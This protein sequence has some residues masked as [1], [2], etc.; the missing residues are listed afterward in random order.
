MA[1]VFL[2]LLA[3][4]PS[5]A[6]PPAT[7]A[8]PKPPP[9]APSSPAATAPKAATTPAAKPSGAATPKAPV[10]PAA[11]KPAAAKPAKAPEPEPM[12]P[13][14]A[15]V[16]VTAPSPTGMWTLRID[17]TG[18]KPVRIPADVRLLEMEVDLP[19]AADPPE[20]DANA[21]KKKVIA[22]KAPAK[23]LRCALPDSLRPSGFPED[24]ALLLAP[25]ESYIES[26]DPNLFCFGKSGAGL[27]GSATVRSQFGWKPKKTFGA[28]KKPPSGPFAVEG[29]EFP[30]VF[31]PQ[32]QVGAP[33]IRL[34]YGL[35]EEKEEGAKGP[36]EAPAPADAKEPAGGGAEGKTEAAKQAEPSNSINPSANPT[37]MD[38]E[39]AG[40]PAK[41][42]AAATAPGEAAG[43][44]T[45]TAGDPAVD[46]KPA[47]IDENAPR[48][49]ISVGRYQDA[50]AERNLSITV[51]A[52]N[53]G[54]RPM[55]AA[56]RPRMLSFMVVGP[57]GAE[58]ECGA[59]TLPRG[60]PREAFRSYKAGE[61]TGFTVLL[62]EICP[63]RTFSRPGLYRVTPTMHAEESGSSL[64]L[65]AFTAV[66][67]ASAPALVRV[68]TG[69]EPFYSAPPS[70]VPTPK[71]VM[72][73][74]EEQPTQS[75]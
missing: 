27:V 9:A 36:A 46:K 5:A 40:G 72:L 4:Q 11:V 49:E 44:K 22:K 34:S 13:A 75:R 1:G 10:K 7:P 25:G 61:T 52:K 53:A 16:W 45:K 42:E 57:D 43:D 29:T 55:L 14:E 58:T 69:P 33:T 21:K 50:A 67:S 38:A 17:N 47:I 19:E 8:Q 24:R 18:P 35:P 30:A 63:R 12:P 39:Q 54:H 71:Q 41:G 32:P 48:L 26:F 70:A 51:T 59:N 15:R 64:G 60:M 68:Q 3:S 6:Q 31:A 62:A 37:K 2:G 65:K 66:V 28:T 73:E 74:E 56:L 20:V 23:P